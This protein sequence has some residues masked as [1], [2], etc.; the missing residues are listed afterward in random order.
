MRPH[1]SQPTERE[2]AIGLVE[3]MVVVLIVLV[4][5]AIGYS[6][7]KSAQSG[8]RLVTTIAAAQDY[9][10]AADRFRRDHNGRYP[11]PPGSRDWPGGRAAKQ[12]PRAA[13]LGTSTYLRRVPEAV[14]NGVV[15][16]GPRGRAPAGIR[17]RR[18]GTGYEI[19]VDVANRPPCALRGG[20]A[21]GTS[22]PTCSTR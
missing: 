1:T 9:A 8:G 11:D 7:I 2:A 17:Y 4:L 22:P 15:V 14:Q 3:V 18:S 12:G 5:V 10:S 19:I 21:T 6:G 16:I 13:A 20:G